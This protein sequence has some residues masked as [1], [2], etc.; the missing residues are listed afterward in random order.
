MQTKYRPWFY[1][2]FIFFV[3]ALLI[4]VAPISVMRAQDESPSIADQVQAIID[5]VNQARIGAGLPA[6]AVHPLLNQAAQAH[7][8]DLVA[9]GIYGHYG[10]DGSNVHTRVQRTGYPSGWVSENWVTAPTPERAMNWWMNDWIHRV[11]ILNANWDEFGVGAAAV[12][13]GFWIYVTDFANSD[14]QASAYVEPVAAAQVE[15]AP[16][17]TVPAGGLDYTIRAGD[18]LL[19]I[20]IRYGLD[21]QDIAL[22]NQLGEADLLQ[23]GQTLRLPGVA[24]AGGATPASGGVK[25]T[26]VSGDTLS[27][28]AA[29]YNIPWEEVA[30]ANGLGEYS[31]LQIGMQLRLPG[32][33]EPTETEADAESER[34]EEEA[35]DQANEEI[36]D[37]QELV[38]DVDGV[39]VQEQSNEAPAQEIDSQAAQY[40]VE[41]GDT[42]F[43]IA[44][45]NGL[46]WEQLAEFNQLDED[47]FLQV[48]QTLSIPSR[49]AGPAIIAPTAPD[50]S[51]A[52]AP[53]T[54]TI[55]PGDTIVGVAVRFGLDW[56]HLLQINGLT[57][58]SILSL[59]QTIRLE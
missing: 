16:P 35:A 32:V 40:T 18:T 49:G 54:Y 26:V 58:A 24:G 46:T 45:R 25:Y 55:R 2:R 9:N 14:G 48:G 59:G 47:S 5:G 51:A 30:A 10:S 20:A 43:S 6:L 53:R 3:F 50:T 17:L 1:A 57:D 4:A 12:G 42:L 28:V 21:W 29:R 39:S 33:E 19:T 8:D 41:P 37:G 22:A 7:V 13:N 36:S 23:I 15:I 52:S 27:G 31:V 38:A 34:V 11:N 44:A 56:E